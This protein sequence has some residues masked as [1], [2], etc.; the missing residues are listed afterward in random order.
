M[1]EP[2]QQPIFMGPVRPLTG[3][4]ATAGPEAVLTE[5]FTERLSQAFAGDILALEVPL[6]DGTVDVLE[7]RLRNPGTGEELLV[8]ARDELAPLEDRYLH[9]LASMRPNQAYRPATLL[10]RGVE[11]RLLPDLVKRGL[12]DELKNT[13]IRPW[14]SADMID[15]AVVYELK[16]E[17]FFQGAIQA[18]RRL[19]YANEA[20]V[21]VGSTLVDRDDGSGFLDATRSMGIGVLEATTGDRIV[22]PPLTGTL[23][24]WAKFLIGRALGRGWSS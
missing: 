1:R 23:T 19:P 24:R 15:R 22:E 12:L 4:A 2:S 6:P 20:W 18:A 11:T 10:A 16:V 3:A 14:L 7:V 9:A 5:S 21:V 8:R 13:V 17:K